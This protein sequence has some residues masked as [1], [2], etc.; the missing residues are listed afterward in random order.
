MKKVMCVLVLALGI[1]VAHAQTGEKSAQYKAAEYLMLAMNMPQNVNDGIADMAEAQAA[2][3]PML[4]SKKDA[5]KKFMVKYMSWEAMGADYTKM[6]ADQFSEA[7]LKELAAFYRTDI[8]NKLPSKQNA[9]TMKASQL[10]QDQMQAH[11][12]ELMK[13]MQ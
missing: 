11:L 7:E 4:A 9:V 10:G 12:D 13:L 5:L 3:N 6:Y 8:G 2:G 1:M